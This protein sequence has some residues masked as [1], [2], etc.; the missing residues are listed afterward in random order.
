[1]MNE[2]NSIVR[3][4][5]NKRGISTEEDI[6]E[7]LSEKPKKTYDPFLLLN[8][9]AGVDLILSTI[10]NRDKICIYGDYDAD[11]IT[12]VAIMMEILSNLTDRLEYYIPS[13]FDEGY[14]LNKEAIQKIKNLGSK[15]IIT[16]DCGSVSFEEVEL[17]KELDLDIIITDHHN[18]TDKIPDCIL[19]NP[20]QKNCKY[21]F[22][23]LAGCGIAFKLAQAIQEKAELP[24]AVLS[25]VLDL[26][27]IGT[28][29]DIVPLIDE[30]RTLVKY[31][32]KAINKSKRQGLVKLIK[33]TGLKYGE[34]N[35]ESVAYV[36]VPHINS[37]GRISKPEIALEL[38]I[39]KD[40][41]PLMEAVNSL[42]LSNKER[43]KLQEEAFLQCIS[44]IEKFHLKDNFKIIFAEGVH[45]GI[46]GIVAGKIK[47]KYERPTIIITKSGEY[48]KGTGRSVKNIDI[49]KILKSVAELF[50]KFGGHSG[51]CGFVMK[52]E[53][54]S[55]LRYS[56]EKEVNDL[57]SKNNLL[58]SLEKVIDFEFI[59]K[60]IDDSLV[61]E[62]E[63][64]APFGN[65][66]EK[67]Y[68]QI[69]HVEIKNILFMGADNKHLRFNSCCVDGAE[70]SCVLFNNAEK[71]SLDALKNKKVSICG[72]PNIN[73]W[74]G[75]EKIQF[76][77]SE[78]KC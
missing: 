64:L 20:K 19:I 14:G 31:G 61:K 23:D 13:R 44:L 33:E 35:S 60:E 39:S 75:T 21:P 69:N 4:L 43:K 32:I 30:N 29:G 66:N 17:A 3:E 15:L 53:N 24:K 45:E 42:I 51:A 48:L 28:I 65:S 77:V 78:I 54:L 46:A 37:A 49:Y 71:Y 26:V 1:M 72:Y 58:F 36:I 56:L 74:K 18:L 55:Q 12:S 10:K 38:L 63:K 67:P 5:L 59:G 47:D 22:K 40:F 73:I 34:I 6:L 11:G 16:V 9:E 7:F 8:M 62:L 76:V 68:F 41:N 52:S 57:H 50:E 25:S 70:M 27:G 2:I